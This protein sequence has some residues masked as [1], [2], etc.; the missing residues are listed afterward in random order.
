[1]SKDKP[2]FVLDSFA[3][4]ALF[5]DEPGAAQVD[6]LVM[7][8]RKGQVE[9]VL[10]LINYG[11]VLYNIE[12][13]QGIEQAKKTVAIIDSMPISI[14]AADRDLTFSAAHLKANFPMAY[15]DAFAAASAASLGGSVVT[16]DPEFR[17]IESVVSV[18]W[19]REKPRHLK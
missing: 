8:A 3:L 4:L 15:G 11:E 9:L 5:Q 14:V 10:T 7:K 6:E 1:M 12:R 19:M 17:K 18:F 2:R 16:G 13:E